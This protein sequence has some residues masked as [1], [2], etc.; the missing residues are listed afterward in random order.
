MKHFEHKIDRRQFL[1]ATAAAGLT[2]GPAF[3]AT[4]PI[5]TRPIPSSGERLPVIGMGSW[6][7]FDVGDNVARRDARAKVLKRF[8]SLGG[9]LVDSS[10][11]Y[12][13]S[14]AVIGYGLNRLAGRKQLFSATKIWT[15]LT[16]YG[17]KQFNNSRRLWGED[18]FDLLQI[19]NLL[20]WEEHLA[21]L[22]RWQSEGQVRYL[23]ITTSHG[24]RHDEFERVMKR[25]TLDFAQF[26]Y[27]IVDRAAEARLL[28]AARERGLAVIINRPF[29]RGLLLDRL[30]SKALPN[31]AVEFDCT[32]WPQFLLKFIVSHP[33]VTCAIPATSRVDHMVENMGAAYGRLPDPALRARMIRY[34]ADL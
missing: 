15:P 8:F 4:R 17:A 30:K 1:A 10:P 27:N 16:W 11:M 14:E 3:A 5:L 20:N 7:T 29:R 26:T 33:A 34:V 9:V 18:R 32:N 6:I 25:E 22:R 12:G 2:A 19:H 28:P 13:S 24:R 23:G 31:W 21:S